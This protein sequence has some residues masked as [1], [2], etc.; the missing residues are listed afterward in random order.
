MKKISLVFCF[1]FL[2]SFSFA[3]NPQYSPPSEKSYAVVKKLLPK[4]SDADIKKFRKTAAEPENV[5]LINDILS[6]LKYRRLI[7][8]DIAIPKI[9]FASMT[10][11]KKLKYTL[12]L[13]FSA[14]KVVILNLDI[15]NNDSNPASKAFNFIIF[16]FALAH[17][18]RHHEDA[19]K[20]VKFP[21]NALTEKNGYT[22][23]VKVLDAFLRMNE[24][25]ADT[26]DIK[27]FYEIIQ[28][29]RNYIANMR[30]IQLLMMK[31]AD[32]LLKNK[33]KICA[34]LGVDEAMFNFFGF[35][36]E[37]QFNAKDGGHIVNIDASFGKPV[38]D[39]RF[40]V[41][42]ISEEVEILSAPA[43]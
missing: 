6:F 43:K 40:A 26:V 23:S 32:I 34:K 30:R 10:S 22:V 20:N 31:A 16:S 15:L 8:G 38:R 37:I 1:S 17:E 36:P 11:N 5:K 7:D 25:T 9:Y 3:Q 18:L 4:V 39:L 35:I 12:G 41:N 27:N 21:S 28:A 14:Q 42:T 29:N 2:F 24:E 13:Y 19:V 33:K